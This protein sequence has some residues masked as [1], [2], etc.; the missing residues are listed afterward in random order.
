MYN[1]GYKKSGN[2]CWF[3]FVYANPALSKLGNVSLKKLFDK[4]FYQLFP[5]FDINLLNTII[6]S[7]NNEKTEELQLLID[8]SN[9]L[10]HAIVYPIRE[11]MCA[12]IFIDH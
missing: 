7:L 1:W 9:K 6:K 10:L 8:D 4:P 5:N 2:N 3:F 12:L 11:D